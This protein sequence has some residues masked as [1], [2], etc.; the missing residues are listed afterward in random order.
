MSYTTLKGFDDLSDKSTSDII[1]DNI[2]QF[3]DWGFINKGGIVN[4]TTP[5]SG[6]Y[7]GDKS[8]LKPRDD[9]RFDEGQVWSSFV[10]GWIWESG[11]SNSQPISISGVTVN[12]IFYTKDDSQYGHYYDYPNGRVIFDSG[13]P[14][15]SSVK[16]NYSYR[17]IQV[18]NDREYDYFRRV[19]EEAYRV[20]DEHFSQY[21][22]G[23]WDVLSEN[24]VQG[25]TISVESLPINRTQPYALGRGMRWGNNTLKCYILTEDYATNVKIADILVDQKEKTLY[26]FDSNLIAE[27]GDFP[28]DYRGMVTDTAKTYPRLVDESINGGYRYNKIYIKETDSQP[29]QQIG[30]I[31]LSTVKLTTEILLSK[32]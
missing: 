13:L 22:S 14:L 16:L 25:P 15:S 26:A 3:L 8:I 10:K 7:A 29:V 4:I 24:T 32:L 30:N 18:V 6:L 12:D 27:S 31:F 23:N 20:D 19:Q 17:Y 21:S 1:G 28:L 11:L 2:I 9:P 5:T